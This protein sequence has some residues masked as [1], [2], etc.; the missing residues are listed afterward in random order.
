MTERVW[1]ISELYYPEET[2]TGYFLTR[3]AEGLAPY[4]PV[5]VLCT[6]PTYSA[7]GVRAPAREVLRGVHIRRCRA[8]RLNK[9]VFLFRLIN[10]VTISLS[11]FFHAL[12]FFGRHDIILVA[13]NPPVLPFL[14]L[15]A[16][17]LRRA[18]CVLLI[19]DVYPD[20]MV[21]AGMLLPG[22]LTVRILNRVT[23]SL[24][25]KMEYISVLGRDMDDLVKKKLRENSRGKTVI[26][27]NW[28]DVDQ[29]VPD[30]RD[31]NALLRE[32]GLTD[33]FVVQYAGNIG[34]VHGIEELL[35][36]ARLLS[37]VDDKV[38]FLFIGSGAK[39]KWLEDAVHE[40][41]LRNVTILPHRPRSDQQVFLNACDV[42]ITAFVPGMAGVGVPSRMYNIFAAGKP[43]IGAV[44][45]N[46]ELALV[47][48]EENVGWIVPPR[49]PEKI[50]EAI[51][52][53]RSNPRLLAEM[54]RRARLAV[55]KKYSVQDVIEAYRRLI[56]GIRNGSPVLAESEFERVG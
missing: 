27:R 52:E 49:R 33:K 5:H 53:A 20:S 17:R 7:R 14:I 19:Q 12:W 11:I 3:I 31:D 34:R 21:A 4:V 46:S 29:V 24:Y 39:K 16:C 38:H 37:V 40:N 41:R 45:K 28:A 35:E 51:L 6:Q 36:A 47:V 26:V 42:A 50:V 1:I 48:R 30:T 10:L 23:K 44:D 18:K 2:S 8:S 25:G 54:G 9:D 22:S 56:S 43:I 13:T 55:E 32:L 15:S